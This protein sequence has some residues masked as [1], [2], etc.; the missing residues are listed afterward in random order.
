M[1]RILG[2]F[3]VTA[4]LL[5]IPFCGWA[6]DAFADAPEDTGIAAAVE[7]MQELGVMVGVTDTEFGA[8]LPVT[9]AM[10]ITVLGR[11]AEAQQA[12]VRGFQDVKA[13]SWY[14]GYVGWAVENGI[15]KGVSDTEFQPD[16]PVRG[17]DLDQMLYRFAEMRGI[18]RK[19]EADHAATVSRGALAQRL[20]PLAADLA[21]GVFTE[22][23]AAEN[24]ILVLYPTPNAEDTSPVS[25]SKPAPVLVVYP[26]AEVNR[27]AAARYA[28]S[29]GL[30]TVAA[31]QGSSIIFVNPVGASWS[32]ADAGAYPAI[33]DMLSDSSTDQRENGIIHGVNFMTG[34][35]ST[36]ILGS[37]QRIY[38]YG[39]GAGADYAA[40][41][42]VKE[43]AGSMTFPDGVTIVFNN[44]CAG[45]T[46]RGLSDVSALEKSDIPVVSVGNSDAVN[47][48]LK[49]NCGEV[50][51]TENAAG[52]ETDYVKLF[53]EFTGT[54]RRQAG[55]LAPVHD[56]AALGIVEKIE[57][58]NV[59]TSPDNKTFSG[60]ERHDIHY[61]T[62]Y[63]EELDVENGKVPLVLAFH[64]GGS[65][66]KYY[67]LATE[68]PLIGK[69]NGFL[70]VA[71]DL[72][73]PQVT[74]NEV[75]Q[76]INHLKEEYSI[77]ESR[78]Y[79]SGF[80]MGGCKSWDLLEQYPEVFAGLAPMDAA[81]ELGKDSFDQDV[82]NMNQ[83]VAV[84]VFYVAGEQSPLPE[85]PCQAEK[86]VDRVRWIF[87]VNKV[88]AEYNVSF[89]AKDTWSEPI[90]GIAGDIVYRVTDKD[91]FTDST[92]TVNLFSSKDG[93]YYT[94]LAAAGNQS[95]EEYARNSWAAWDFLSQFSRGEDGSI[96]IS[97]VT[98]R[99]PADD[100]SV[101][102]N[103]YNQ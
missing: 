54:Y 86:L 66:A 70:T 76:L 78:I 23:K 89:E 16:A 58:F 96:V 77:D 94:A 18:E 88:A 7:R 81:N 39:E 73:Y 80:S 1:R 44:T 9:R 69:E 10:V 19:P 3:L 63:A 95:H 79:A 15:V 99:L 75:I 35:S 93:H 20:L 50:L 22:L 48:A 57:A 38:I 2:V 31:E 90:W 36:S 41:N 87:G 65:T 27:V 67:A 72:H 47:A 92:L 55:F 97:P 33:V 12:E 11:L 103:N 17:E 29:T 46:L 64:G 59:E 68:W 51:A 74:P 21:E 32:Q 28:R 49:T 6:P 45:A 60:V 40:A 24:R 43:I 4:M 82:K 85:M 34:E 61:L 14:S 8:E 26:D 25:L 52:S 98:Y 91:Y 37:S 13:G 83:D 71:V 62:Y 101:S 53:Q 5:C 56:W 30:E 84:P 42:L 100:G 102:A